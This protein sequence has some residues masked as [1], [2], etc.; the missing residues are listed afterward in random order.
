MLPILLYTYKSMVGKSIYFPNWA[1]FTSHTNIISRNP[2]VFMAHFLHL[3]VFPSKNIFQWAWLQ[4][5]GARVCSCILAH[6]VHFI[7][8]L[9][10]SLSL[11]LSV[12]SPWKW[13]ISLALYID[14]ELDVTWHSPPPEAGRAGCC[15]IAQP[16]CQPS[17]SA[18]TLS[19]KKSHN[20]KFVMFLLFF[21]TTLHLLPVRNVSRTSLPPLHDKDIKSNVH[22]SRSPPDLTSWLLRLPDPKQHRLPLTLKQDYIKGHN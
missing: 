5:E 8:V 10:S 1:G 11:S 4:P 17:V 6:V 20:R 22:P 7:L 19:I 16:A 2:V 15:V 3:Q 13:C 14:T 18:M 12:P 21:S 9:T